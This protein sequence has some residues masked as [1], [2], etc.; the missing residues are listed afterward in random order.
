MVISFVCDHIVCTGRQ[1][2]ERV[3]VRGR[4]GQG[5]RRITENSQLHTHANN[6]SAVVWPERPS[7]E[8]KKRSVLTVLV[9]HSRIIRARGIGGRRAAGGRGVLPNERYDSRWGWKSEKKN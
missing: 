8:K 6:S 3:L 2:L 9:R 1:A 4:A 5:A 7:P